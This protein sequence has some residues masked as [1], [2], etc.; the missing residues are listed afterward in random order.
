L[1][2]PLRIALIGAGIMGQQHYR[3]LKTLTEATLCAVADPGPQAATLAAEWGVAYF[4]DHGR[5]WS[6][7]SRTR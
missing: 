7:R 6:R 5:C 2:S 3:H 1:N 4:A